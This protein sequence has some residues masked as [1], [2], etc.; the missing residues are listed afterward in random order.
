MG[1]S[2]QNG[3][4]LSAVRHIGRLLIITP[5]IPRFV[6]YLAPLGSHFDFAQPVGQV[7]TLVFPLAPVAKD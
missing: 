2:R 7:G 3:E 6:G 5:E 1:E 4:V